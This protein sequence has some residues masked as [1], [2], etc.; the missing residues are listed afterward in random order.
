[1]DIRRAYL[2]AK[3][4]AIFDGGMPDG[5]LSVLNQ[6][7]SNGSISQAQLDA[8]ILLCRRDD[9]VLEIKNYGL[10]LIVGISGAFQGLEWNDIAFASE[11]VPGL[12]LSNTTA[13]FQLAVSIYQ[14]GK[15]KVLWILNTATDQEVE[16]YVAS[17]DP[18]WP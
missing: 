16:N 3:P 14:Y 2:I 15:S 10:D 6:R 1:M 7:C 5:T 12:T 11:W 8:A 18:S 17:T 13:D 4:D 9:R